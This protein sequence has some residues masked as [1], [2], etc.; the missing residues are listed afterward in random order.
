MLVEIP[1]PR[2]KI[3]E[4]D[5]RSRGRYGLE[6]SAEAIGNASSLD[7][8]FVVFTSEM[9]VLRIYGEFRWKLK[10]NGRRRIA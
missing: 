5:E 3:A 10:A 1:A 7:G 6:T 8:E 2:R 4:L 9:D